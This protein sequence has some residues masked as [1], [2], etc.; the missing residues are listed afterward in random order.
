[1][2]GQPV[3]REALRQTGWGQKEG[4]SGGQPRADGQA[5]RHCKPQ[6]P[7]A[8]GLTLG[9]QVAEQWL[10]VVQGTGG[11]AAHAVLGQAACGAQ[12]RVLVL[13]RAVSIGDGGARGPDQRQG[14]HTLH[15][16]LREGAAS[17]GPPGE[18]GGSAYLGP[19]PL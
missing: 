1:M 19:L 13:G 4:A 16:V 5:A 9:L 11:E 6:D 7:R 14:R 3:G 12:Q 18:L 2:T 17:E 8:G 15:H 10:G